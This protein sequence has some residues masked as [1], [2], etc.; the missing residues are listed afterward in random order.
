HLE[1]EADMIQNDHE[2]MYGENP[3]I[4]WL[5]GEIIKEN[6]TIKIPGNI[7]SKKFRLVMGIWEPLKNKRIKITQSDVPTTNREIYIA[8][9][10]VE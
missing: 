8:D 4:E 9:I 1:G 6:S 3:I 2:G 5:H 7:K 10:I